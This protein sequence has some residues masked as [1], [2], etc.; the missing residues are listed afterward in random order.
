M[1]L[2]PLLLASLLM[3]APLSESELP[4]GRYAVKISGM[5]TTTCGRA[6]ERELAKLPAVE[7][8][9][10]DFDSETATVTV[11]L[12]AVLTQAALRRAL[13]RAARLVDLGTRYEPGEIKYLP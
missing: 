10:V 12:D 2:L 4:S 1:R 8:A 9:S 11:K 13:R 7:S 3:G 5:L 6:I